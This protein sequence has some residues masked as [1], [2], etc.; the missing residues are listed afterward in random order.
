[1]AQDVVS[2]NFSRA[3]KKK[4]CILLIIEW[5]V[6]YMSVRSLLV[7][8]GVELYIFADHLLVLVSEMGD[9]VVPSII[10]DVCFLSTLVSFCFI[11]F[12]VLLFRAYTFKIVLSSWWVDSFIVM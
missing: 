10:V 12:E 3:L 5:T 11:C 6:L 8:G 2:V 1:M 7:D 4:M 9:V